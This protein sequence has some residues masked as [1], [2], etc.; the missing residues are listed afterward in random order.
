MS[1]LEG[2][3]LHFHPQEVAA[4]Y[5]GERVHPIYVDLGPVSNCNHRCL[6]C[7]YYYLDHAAGMLPEDVMLRLMDELAEMKVKSICFAGDGEPLLNKGTIPA[8]VKAKALG[9]DVAMSTNGVLLD[10]EKAAALLP[11]LTWIRYSINGGSAASYAVVHQ[12]KEADFE[13]VINSLSGA[14]KIKKECGLGVTLGV[15]FVF[16]PENAETVFDLARQV[17]ECGADYFVVK[18]FYHHSGNAYKVPESFDMRNYSNMLGKVEALSRG[19]FHSAVRWNTS[20]DNSSV[21]AYTVCHGLP[22]ISII[23]ASG[24]VFPCL[25]YQD[26]ALHSFGNINQ[27]SF[28]DIWYGPRR[29]KVMQYMDALDKNKCQP[30]C[31]HH[32]INK[33]LW[34]IKN[35]N[36]HWKF[37]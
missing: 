26:K 10:R 5:R 12:A 33:Y 34:E 35:H 4:W 31:R 20:R 14:A 16:L 27:M 36:D 37:I 23:S 11:A 30:N 19:G 21:R 32:A 28:R 8:A 6:F 2:H 22:F 29:K 13:R 9:L 25:P 17:K 3:K 18:P 24:D 1:S 15:Q 7:G